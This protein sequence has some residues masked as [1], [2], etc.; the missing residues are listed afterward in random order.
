MIN[1]SEQDWK[2]KT[3]MLAFVEPE[4]LNGITH[5]REELDSYDKDISE[6]KDMIEYYKNIGNNKEVTI[7]KRMLQQAKTEKRMI[8]EML[9]KNIAEV[10]VITK[11]DIK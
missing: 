3:L 2:H 11:Y 7:W 1:T 8:R 4:A 10:E 9:E 6:I 5:S